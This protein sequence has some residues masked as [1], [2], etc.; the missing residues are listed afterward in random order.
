[1]EISDVNAILE[2]ILFEFPVSQIG[3]NFPKWVDALNKT[4][5]SR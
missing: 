3:I 5:R 2:R 1:M 4:H